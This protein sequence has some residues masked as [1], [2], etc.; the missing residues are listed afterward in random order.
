MIHEAYH[1][2]FLLITMYV[3]LEQTMKPAVQTLTMGTMNTTQFKTIIPLATS[4]N[5]QQIQVPGSKFHY[6]RLVP[7]STASGSSQT[8]SSSSST[9]TQPLSQGLLH[10]NFILLL[11]K[12]YV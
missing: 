5:V 7:A 6:V 10:E 4:P 3:L 1:D 2:M 8:V 11:L 12:S 9:N